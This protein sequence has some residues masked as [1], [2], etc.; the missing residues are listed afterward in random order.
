MTYGLHHEEHRCERH[1][2]GGC[3]CGDGAPEPRSCER[4]ARDEPEIATTTLARPPVVSIDVEFRCPKCG[5]GY[6]G[7]NYATEP[8]ASGECRGTDDG[9]RSCDFTWPRSDDWRYFV[10]VTVE[11]F[12]SREAYDEA[13][14]S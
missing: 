3:S 12:T 11:S 10:R 6:F 5:G 8:N 1:G 2:Y 13:M 7:T 14:K 4:S 9:S